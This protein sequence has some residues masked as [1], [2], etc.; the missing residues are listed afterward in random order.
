MEAWELWDNKF[1]TLENRLLEATTE[2]RWDVQQD[3]QIPEARLRRIEA[4]AKA[5][6]G[7]AAEYE[8]ARLKAEAER[9]KDYE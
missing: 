1:T 7:L 4:A 6:V 3:R 9:A 5:V 8:E 2:V